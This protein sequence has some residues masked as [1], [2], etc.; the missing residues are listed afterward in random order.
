MVHHR[1]VLAVQVLEVLT[2]TL[3]FLKAFPIVR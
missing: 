3:L 2:A 1:Q